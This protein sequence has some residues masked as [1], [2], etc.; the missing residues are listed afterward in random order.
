V[1][2]VLSRVFDDTTNIVSAAGR[3]H[4]SAIA[5][6]LLDRNQPGAF[7]Q[8]M[9]ELGA[10]ICL[11]RNPHCLVCPVSD[12][13]RARDAGRENE[14]PVKARRHEGVREYRQLFW[15]ERQGKLLVWRRPSTSR[16]MPGFWELPERAELGGAAAGRKLGSFRHTITFHE[17]LFEVAEVETETLQPGGDCQWMPLRDLDSRPTSTILRKA[18]R[19][20]EKHRGQCTVTPIAAKLGGRG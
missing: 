7:N 9:M 5:D 11:P 13:C 12:L 8:A 16:L 1:F 2:R 17:Y 14:L 6:K 4:F 15:V 10:T 3:N 19:V 20:V 18:R